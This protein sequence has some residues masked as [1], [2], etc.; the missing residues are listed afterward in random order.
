MQLECVSAKHL[1]SQDSRDLGVQILCMSCSLESII[2]HSGK[3]Q[4]L[5]F[6]LL[7]FF[8]FFVLS[9]VGV[10][11]CG[12]VLREILDFEPV[13]VMS[14]LASVFELSS[15]AQLPFSVSFRS[16]HIECSSS[17]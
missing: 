9:A 1:C 4:L 10:C 6:R 2:E 17:V 5:L 3:A 16:F 7:L 14:V 8:P 12:V 13:H 15:K 11:E